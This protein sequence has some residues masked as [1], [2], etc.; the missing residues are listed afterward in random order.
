MT[1][2][3][4]IYSSALLFL[5]VDRMSIFVFVTAQESRVY[6]SKQNSLIIYLGDAA[7]LVLK[8]RL[9]M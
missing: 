1:A 5:L 3:C 9:L 7:F 6:I 8:S 2:S 4:H